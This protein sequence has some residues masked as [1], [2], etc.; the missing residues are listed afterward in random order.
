MPRRR[1]H[2]L[3]VAG[4]S[5]LALGLVLAGGWSVHLGLSVR[6]HLEATRDA[7]L[8]LRTARL[9]APGDP[10]GVTIADARR[11]AEQARRLTGGPD[12]ALLTHVPFAGDAATTIRGLSEAAA[13]LTDVLAGV[14]HVAAPL[15]PGGGALAGGDQN[16]TLQVLDALAPALDRAVVRIA[17]ARSR[18]ART[19]AR[20]GLD[21]VDR[22]RDTMV[23][24]TGRVQGWAGA[25]ANVAALAP[26]MLGRDGPRRYFLAFQTNAE[27]R[28]T[29]GLVGAYGIL[30]A[31]RGRLGIA[32]LSADNGLASGSKPVV[33]H[34]PR[35]LARYG[36]GA[37]SM[38][39]VSNL[40][41]HF[42]Y[43][44]STWA[45]LWQRQTGR[46]VDGAIA[47]DP[48]GLA[49]VLE[50]IGPVRLPGGETV[51][52]GNVVDLTE[53]AAYER[54]PDPADRK[55][56]L[57]RIAGAVSEALI[58][59]NPEPARLLPVLSRLVAERRI[60]IWNR[61]EDEERRLAATPLGGVLPERPGPYAALVVNNS[62]GT[63]LDYYLG[64]SLTYELGPCRPDGKRPATV[65]FALANDVPRGHLP[66]YVTDRL[67]SPGK[68]HVP[69]SNLLWVSLY[70]AVGAEATGMRVDGRSSGFYT[71]YER[72]H[73]VFSSV[74]E[75]AP[76]QTRTVELDLLEPYT[77]AAPVVPVQ[78]LVR[79]QET[80]IRRN[81]EGCPVR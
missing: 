39:S 44:A 56:Y 3:V 21:V 32:R 31:D 11:H 50:I 64:R 79:P 76:R 20:T 63:K 55:K 7:L 30:T 80:V 16:R 15:M 14:Q 17:A 43:A 72:S 9:G 26:P 8:R 48:V 41:P 24:E 42:P 22:A 58:G 59:A 2:R 10:L 6:E 35:F 62:A 37:T 60:Q 46:T 67:D 18:L 77:A 5:S 81:D 65:R 12:W 57:M 19:P 70:G 23:R 28:G 69:G 27:A 52:A 1:K 61:R 40:S 54:Y 78:P 45:G 13:E 29:G 71:E 34:G 38:L 36:P 66:G 53:R 33:D 51:T 4:L 68:A 75:F 73:P 47:T 74:L 25:A 49:R